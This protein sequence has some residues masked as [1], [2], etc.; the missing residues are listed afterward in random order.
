MCE[1]TTI[2]MAAGAAV[3]G[4][5]AISQ[6]QQAKAMGNYQAAQAAADADAARGYAELEAKS[7]RDA[8]KKQRSA[9]IAAQAGAGVSVDVGTAELINQEIDAGGE[10]DAQM[11]ILTG[12]TRARQ[13]NAQGEAAR[14]GGSNAARAG[15]MN[16]GATALSAGYKVASGWKS[17][18]DPLDWMRTSNRGMGD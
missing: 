16:A 12:G 9:A 4:L 18:A 11:A 10:Y 3:S 8:A 15:F 2:L 5:S 13:L 7:I 14:I 1:P 6:G 17:V